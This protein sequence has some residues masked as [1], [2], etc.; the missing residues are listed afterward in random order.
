MKNEIKRHNKLT[1]KL[2]I[3]NKKKLIKAKIST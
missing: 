2:K 1:K 3:K